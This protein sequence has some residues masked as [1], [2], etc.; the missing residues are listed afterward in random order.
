VFIYAVN[1][2]QLRQTTEHKNKRNSLIYK[3]YLGK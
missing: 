1:N 3:D 2:G